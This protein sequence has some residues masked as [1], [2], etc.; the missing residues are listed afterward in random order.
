MSDHSAQMLSVLAEM[1]DLLRLI[2]E[3]AIAERDKKLREALLV[4]A[5]TFLVII[6]LFDSIYALLA[7]PAGTVPSDSRAQLF[8]RFGGG[9]LLGGGLW[10]ALP[11]DR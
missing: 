8:S 7:G 5:A 3:P 4:I 2:A 10:L 6:G 9:A 1:R 11:H